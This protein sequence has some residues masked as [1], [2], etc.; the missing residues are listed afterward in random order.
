MY[1]IST[2]ILCGFRGFGPIGTRMGADFVS[3]R[4]WCILAPIITL[5]CGPTIMTRRK[6]PLIIGGAVI[7]LVAVCAAAWFYLM[8]SPEP[9]VTLPGISYSVEE[10]ELGALLDYADAREMLE[11]HLPGIADLRQLAIA[12]PLT[13]LDLQ[14]YYPRL[15]TDEKLAALDA[16]LG[17]L[18]GSA[19]VVYTTGS[20]LVGVILDDPEARAIVDKYLPGFSTH[21][22]IDQ[23][24]GFTLNFMQKF[25]RE[26]LTDEKLANMN[27]DFEA[28]AKSRAGLE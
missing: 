20:T 15:I 3:R 28:L 5:A 14:P 19:V 4:H 1:T 26:Q 7:V 2:Y 8:P 17:E 6:L 22:D 23:G 27:R 10:S 25:D 21:P 9:A 13:L 18:K 24:R 11:R 12:R 16:E